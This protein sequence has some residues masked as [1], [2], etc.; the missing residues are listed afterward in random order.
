MTTMT[1][2]EISDVF[3]SY[4]LERLNV[5][6][7]RRGNINCIE[8]GVFG[9][10]V[11][12][13][14]PEVGY[15]N[16]IQNFT[17]SSIR[18]IDAIK[19]FYKK[20]HL[21]FTVP[22]HHGKNWSILNKWAERNGGTLVSTRGILLSNLSQLVDVKSDELDYHPEMVN[23]SNIEEFVK[24]YV[25]GFEANISN[26]KNI[27]ANMCLL[28][29]IPDVRLYIIKLESEAIGVGVIYQKNNVT[30]LAGGATKKE[31]RKKGA[32][33]YSI[34]YRIIEAIKRRSAFIVSWAPINHDSYNNMRRAGLEHVYTDHIYLMNST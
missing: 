9:G 23:N 33:M 21:K 30:Y 10:T 29:T 25:L 5:Y 4:D 2:D 15:F 22:I 8:I 34:R 7:N 28:L 6:K 19:D 11:C 16:Y 17:E 1:H 3:S 14:F 24:V 12:T 32:H 13:K 27:C 18:N 20:D 31:Y 26:F